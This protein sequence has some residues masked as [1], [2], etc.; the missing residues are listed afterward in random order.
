MYIFFKISHTHTHTPIRV[1]HV[2]R[3]HSLPRTLVQ[4]AT[5]GD[6]SYVYPTYQSALQRS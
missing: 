2:M 5:P 1:D 3:G 4:D 6:V